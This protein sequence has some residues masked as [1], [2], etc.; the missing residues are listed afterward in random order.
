MILYLFQ[1][2]VVLKTVII[3]ILY[4]DIPAAYQP[5]SFKLSELYKISCTAVFVP[6]AQLSSFNSFIFYV[7]TKKNVLSILQRYEY[8][9]FALVFPI[10]HCG[11]LK[12]HFNNIL[13]CMDTGYRMHGNIV[14]TSLC[15]VKN[16]L[17]HWTAHQYIGFFGIADLTVKNRTDGVTLFFCTDSH[18]RNGKADG[19]R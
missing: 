17:N 6:A 18:I 10:F 12:C 9:D 3:R 7:L 16:H 4:I 5:T 8:F 13:T 11:L 15:I 1:R 2:D 19:F 14:D